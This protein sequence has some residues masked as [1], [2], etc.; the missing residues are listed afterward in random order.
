M[1][2]ESPHVKIH[3]PHVHVPYGQKQ[4]PYQ[5][6][7]QA[8]LHDPKIQGQ[9]YGLHL[10]DPKQ[11][12]QQVQQY[13]PHLYGQKLGQNAIPIFNPKQHENN[14]KKSII[15]LKKKE[16]ENLSSRR[17]EALSAIKDADAKIKVHAEIIKN[18]EQ[19]L[20]SPSANLPENQVKS[21]QTQIADM[22]EKSPEVKSVYEA[23]KKAHE[24]TLK[25]VSRSKVKKALLAY[26]QA[27]TAKNLNQ[28]AMVAQKGSYVPGGIRITSRKTSLMPK[29]TELDKKEVEL[30]QKIQDK[31]MTP[32]DEKDLEKIQISKKTMTG[33]IVEKQRNRRRTKE[34]QIH[35]DNG[36][37]VL[38]EQFQKN[39]NIPNDID[40]VRFENNQILYNGN[41]NKTYSVTL[42]PA[43][44]NIIK[45]GIEA[46]KIN[47][48]ISSY[49]NQIKQSVAKRTNGGVTY[50]TMMGSKT[51][52]NHRTKLNIRPITYT[53]VVA[54]TTPDPVSVPTTP[55][56]F[57]GP[58]P[59]TRT[60][61][62]YRNGNQSAIKKTNMPFIVQPFPNN[63]SSTNKFISNIKKNTNL[64]MHNIT[65]SREISESIDKKFSNTIKNIETELLKSQENTENFIKIMD[66]YK[67]L[68]N[69]QK[70]IT[71]IPE[72]INALQTTSAYVI[73][74][75]L[76]NPKNPKNPNKFT[77]DE[78]KILEVYERY[79]QNS[80]QQQFSENL[81]K[82]NR[83]LAVSQTNNE[84]RMKTRKNVPSSSSTAVSKAT[85]EGSTSFSFNNPAFK[86]NV[87][88][89]TPTSAQRTFVVQSPNTS[90][91]VNNPLVTSNP[92][93]PN[94]ARPVATPGFVYPRTGPLTPPISFRDVS[95]QPTITYKGFNNPVF[96]MN[97]PSSSVVESS[98][99]STPFLPNTNPFSAAPINA[100]Q[101]PSDATPKST[102]FA[103]TVPGVPSR[104]E[105]QNKQKINPIREIEGKQ[106]REDIIDNATNTLNKLL[107]SKTLTHKNNFDKIITLEE[108]EMNLDN[109]IVRDN[110]TIEVLYNNRFVNPR[111][112]QLELNNI[113]EDDKQSLIKGIRTN[114]EIKEEKDLQEDINKNNQEIIKMKQLNAKHQGL[115]TDTY[116]SMIEEYTNKNN[117]LIEQLKAKQIL[118]TTIHHKNIPQ[119]EQV[120]TSA[121]LAKYTKELEAANIKVQKAEEDKKKALEDTAKHQ[122]ELEKAN[123]KVVELEKAREAA[124][125]EVQEKTNTLEKLLRQSKPNPK[126]LA[127]TQKAKLAAEEALNIA[128][129]KANQ[130][131]LKL[132]NYEKALNIERT[133]VETA[134]AATTEALAAKEKAKA[135]IQ[136]LRKELEAEK[137]RKA[138]SITSQINASIGNDKYFGSNPRFVNQE[139]SA[140]GYV[141]QEVVK[142]EY[143]LAS[144]TITSNER[145]NI[146][147]KNIA[148]ISNT[149][150]VVPYVNKPEYIYAAPN[151]NEPLQ[152]VSVRQNIGYK[153]IQ[154]KTNSIYG[155]IPGVIQSHITVSNTGENL[156]APA[157]G[158]NNLKNKESNY[159]LQRRNEGLE[160]SDYMEIFPKD[161]SQ[162]EG[163]NT[164]LKEQEQRNT[165]LE[166]EAEVKA[167][168]AAQAKEFKKQFNAKQQQFIN[169]NNQISQ[170]ILNDKSSKFILA[171]IIRKQF[172]EKIE[173]IDKEL[174]FVQKNGS[175]ND[176]DNK[177]NEYR[178]MFGIER[179]FNN[180]EAFISNLH[181]ESA[182]NILKDIKTNNPLFK[183]PNIQKE[184]EKYITFQKNNS[185]TLFSSQ[186]DQVVRDEFPVPIKGEIVA[187]VPVP[188]SGKKSI[189]NTQALATNAKTSNFNNPNRPDLGSVQKPGQSTALTE[190][191]LVAQQAEK[192]RAQPEQA[193]EQRKEQQAA[194]QVAQPEQ[195][196]E[197]RKA[198]Q[199]EKERVE[200]EQ[201]D[202]GRR[203][204]NYFGNNY[205]KGEEMA[206]KIKNFDITHLTKNKDF[207]AI[208]EPYI[209]TNT[210][211]I[212][213]SILDNDI[214]KETLKN[215][216]NNDLINVITKH[217]EELSDMSIN[218]N[219]NNNKTFT[220][221]EKNE[222]KIKYN[223]KFQEIKQLFNVGE[224]VND[225]DDLRIALKTSSAANI[226][227]YMK[228]NHPL[229]ENPEIKKVLD[230]YINYQKANP[231]TKYSENFTTLLKTQRGKTFIENSSGNMYSY[232]NPES[233][234]ETVDA[235][236]NLSL[237]PTNLN[238]KPNKNKQNVALS[239]KED[240]VNELIT[241]L[242]LD[243]DNPMINSLKKLNV[244][245]LQGLLDKLTLLSNNNK[246][247]KLN[248]I[249]KSLE[250]SRES[251]E[252]RT[253][254]AQNPNKSVDVT[255]V[256]A[257]QNLLSNLGRDPLIGNIN[258][259]R[260]KQLKT[261]KTRKT[262]TNEMRAKVESGS[263]PTQN[264][265]RKVMEANRREK[266]NPRR[267]SKKKEP[268][269]SQNPEAI[270]TQSTLQFNPEAS[271]IRPQ[272]GVNASFNNMPE[273]V[274]NQTELPRFTNP[275]NLLEVR[276]SVI[277]EKNPEAI[278]TQPTLQSKPEA[279]SNRSQLGVNASFNNMPEVVI[280]QTELPRFTN[281][282]NILD[283]SP[284]VN[285]VPETSKVS[286]IPNVE[287]SA[288]T[289]NLNNLGFTPVLENTRAEL[290]R[291]K[292]YIDVEET[293]EGEPE[294]S[295]NQNS[296][297]SVA[298]VITPSVISGKNARNINKP[299]NIQHTK[300]TPEEIQTTKFYRSL[301][302]NKKKYNSYLAMTNK[303]SNEAQKLKKTPQELTNKLK[304][305]RDNRKRSKKQVANSAKTLLSQPINKNIQV[306][307]PNT[308]V[309][310]SLPGTLT[311]E[312]TVP[313]TDNEGH[314]EV[315]TEPKNNL[316]EDMTSAYP[317]NM[318]YATEQNL[319]ENTLKK[320]SIDN[321]KAS[322]ILV[323]TQMRNLLKQKTLTT[324]EKERKDGMLKNLN[325]INAE[326]LRREIPGNIVASTISPLYTPIRNLSTV[327]PPSVPPPSVPPP[328]V[329]TPSDSGSTIKSFVENLGKSRQNPNISEYS[330][331]V[332]SRDPEPVGYSEPSDDASTYAD[333]SLLSE[334]LYPPDDTGYYHEIPGTS[335]TPINTGVTYAT[336]NAQDENNIYSE[337]NNTIPEQ[338]TDHIYDEIN[339]TQL[340]R[341]RTD[342]TA[343][344]MTNNA[345]PPIP[346]V[347]NP[348][349][350]KVDKPENL[351]STVNEP[352][353][354]VYP[355]SERER[356][357]S[358][359][360]V[361][362]GN[363]N[364]PTVDPETP[365]NK[366]NLPNERRQ[367]LM[368]QGVDVYSTLTPRSRQNI[369]LKRNSVREAAARAKTKTSIKKA[370][371][372]E[373][374][375]PPGGN[376][377]NVAKETGANM[378]N[379]RYNRNDTYSSEKLKIQK[380]EY[381]KL[382]NELRYLQ[383][384]NNE[385]SREKKNEIIKKL[386][387]I[388][389]KDD[390]IRKTYMPKHDS[391]LLPVKR[392]PIKQTRGS[393]STTNLNLG[394]APL[395]RVNTKGRAI[396]NQNGYPI[397]LEGSV[398][399]Q[400]K[401][402][403][404]NA[405]IAGL[406][407]EPS[408]ENSEKARA[409]AK[410]ANLEAK[411][412]E[413]QQKL[414]QQQENAVKANQA[415]LAQLRK[416]Q[417]AARAKKPST[418]KA[419]SAPV[420][421][422]LATATNKSKATV[423]KQAR[424]AAA[425]SSRT[426]NKNVNPVTNADLAALG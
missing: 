421:S 132:S 40:K 117:Q 246:K 69:V 262:L 165:V 345:L 97:S 245:S 349:Y 335:N 61:N 244:K 216:I 385:A 235:V 397:L 258:L 239:K 74:G 410:K 162:D 416:K 108:N 25:K 325:I 223:E 101:T 193:A 370:N 180:K 399:E 145:R 168:Q 375:P 251:R 279:S 127:E 293:V 62:R 189:E 174:Q 196:A 368:Q 141:N 372:E 254:K 78:L 43:Q 333:P 384:S 140:P 48:M 298:N 73:L 265:L 167:Q 104:T 353:Y 134:I 346:I 340:G 198:Q 278:G 306:N 77:P 133:K 4:G 287:T 55:G 76:K 36:L 328:S 6:P 395:I 309:R 183:D 417:E 173:N 332:G 56:P 248:N 401:H 299:S 405:I 292:G 92:S 15:E 422:N 291:N 112:Y 111:P 404:R 84:L 243:N 64:N 120:G 391:E 54:G 318:S 286:T 409:A 406:K 426:F 144:G 209:D 237:P 358:T 67:T 100:G 407:D 314:Y 324:E 23:L 301:S 16:Y 24:S 175:L 227:E 136:N 327:P 123:K 119:K 382:E 164:A 153:N 264:N 89:T 413:E 383:D 389:E 103:S 290:N 49:N 388:R 50:A 355:I 424:V 311:V 260:I 44:V 387:K 79:H 295:L 282:N 334:P 70:E 30:K 185:N 320:E 128:T 86:P 85:P 99:V 105:L 121:I 294:V 313:K 362:S 177:I 219:N 273:V 284:S 403:M 34:R 146:N 351:I 82:L 150:G 57:S 226:L 18:L 373:P 163:Q 207:A 336:P 228:D 230:T 160:S 158:A 315:M 225:I 181:K 201:E 39:Q 27:Q 423:R 232:A 425:L 274:I 22:K 238:N 420:M 241:M 213:P 276:P 45:K 26:E 331:V 408:K 255:S 118:S 115:P 33:L 96:G 72:F 229:Y 211:Q 396:T 342:S 91:F 8:H 326:L 176:V 259:E 339:N 11:G 205:T 289:A 341:S 152:P 359:T 263:P 203:M 400:E 347:N 41:D 20:N 307:N 308:S 304:K 124:I 233:V 343:S 214:S 381:I 80:P 338:P 352:Q 215:I 266:K 319:P 247:S 256:D 199:A 52:S 88:S 419:N 277:N 94:A 221:N 217:M 281:S 312:E 159:E 98:T 107:Q 13:G 252:K 268:S 14:T 218:N 135:E 113:T 42:S 9:Q 378:S 363:T 190:Q 170:N 303:T 68:F 204:M 322:K 106:V 348:V 178:K 376:V 367:T 139:V 171:D 2:E 58:G 356:L 206:K 125:A 212:N 38:R 280:N 90:L 380:K 231:T 95:N 3:S 149:Y 234:T 93:K 83:A 179:A 28:L 377:S 366:L 172:D 371:L 130:A 296:S 272:L 137:Q 337:I 418:K 81:E 270:G 114:Q 321:L 53:E 1:T 12:Q 29:I 257:T 155:V 129:E 191:D 186:Y 288:I 253:Q 249:K 317:V 202:A 75:N 156:T 51:G 71:T 415:R 47:K 166:A 87:T 32:E 275:N 240:K 31:G 188:I 283:V 122:T 157:P 236:P 169:N 154:N 200:K 197:Q 46:H 392:E 379:T 59:R 394:E 192:E 323:D 361:S 110:N 65:K 386:N 354:S 7:H 365:Y 131:T 402:K 161:V 369:N 116:T 147:K 224:N 66:K 393:R 350:N 390:E 220:Q 210:K 5:G 142:P 411:I 360:S 60:N 109:F 148:E 305:E 138:V 316:Y 35:I 261:E 222:R 374:N 182:S 329:P 17:T 357:S 37:N 250:K 194:Q 10:H 102:P 267:K 300:K 285:V 398:L 330:D 310:L 297:S 302:N 208:I 269:T 195:A 19:Q 184:L 271:S 126:L 364:I 143:N 151:Y 414:K 21:L 187:N 412:K 344:S 63:S 242:S